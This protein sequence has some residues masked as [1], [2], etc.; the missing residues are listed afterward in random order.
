MSSKLPCKIYCATLAVPKTSSEI[1]MR[2]R[3]MHSHLW[4]IIENLN[5]WVIVGIEFAFDRLHTAVA[6]K[7]NKN[8]NTSSVFCREATSNQNH[9]ARLNLT[10][11]KYWK[12]SNRDIIGT[13]IS[14]LSDIHFWK[15]LIN[16]CPYQYLVFIV[17]PFPV[18]ARQSKCLWSCHQF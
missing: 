4:K 10:A 14:F 9:Q 7:P 6:V 8:V 11:Y 12:Y 15:Y 3:F 1:I 17:I 18:L 16:Q 2:S 13:A 5:F